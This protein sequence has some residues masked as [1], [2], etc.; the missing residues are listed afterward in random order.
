MCFRTKLSE[1]GAGPL[2]YVSC[3]YAHSN[4]NLAPRAMRGELLHRRCF[5]IHSLNVVDST[6]R[7]AFML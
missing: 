1:R 6:S 5:F 3:I 2:G 7:Y 4:K